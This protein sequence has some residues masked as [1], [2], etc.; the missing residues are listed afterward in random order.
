MAA[1]EWKIVAQTRDR[2]GESAM[3]HPRERA[4]Y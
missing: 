1:H 3:W 2:L 4:I